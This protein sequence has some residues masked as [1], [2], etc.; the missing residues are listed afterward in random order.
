MWSVAQNRPAG[1]RE[2]LKRIETAVSSAALPT[3]GVLV[4]ATNGD[5]RLKPQSCARGLGITSIPR[6]K[7]G[8]YKDAWR[9]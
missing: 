4:D 1:E 9:R 3:A 2:P 8:L 6:D 5:Y 7:I